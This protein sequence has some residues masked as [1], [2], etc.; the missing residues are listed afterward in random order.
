[1]GKAANFF[2]VSR[3]FWDLEL[4]NEF[5]ILNSDHVFMWYKHRDYYDYL[6]AVEVSFDLDSLLALA[7]ISLEI[8]EF[9]YY[10]SKTQRDLVSI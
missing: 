7:I 9:S 8:V 1:M 4:Q 6:D 5:T 3:K 2:A 10:M